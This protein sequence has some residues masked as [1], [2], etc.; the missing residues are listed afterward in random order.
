MKP[1]EN[2]LPLVSVY[3]PTKNRFTLLQK[4]V[5]SVFAQTYTNIELVICNDGSTDGT[6]KYLTNLKPAGSIKNIHILTNEESKGA[7]NARNKAIQNANG[8]FVTGL[9]DDDIFLPNRIAS[10]VEHYDPKYAFIC[11][12]MIWDYGNK[13]RT[14]DKKPGIYTLS[15]QLSYNEATTQILVERSRIL[16]LNGFD[17]SFVACQDYD[18][19]TRLIIKF[20]A[21][22]RIADVTYI[23]NDTD[24]TQRMTANPKSVKGY[25]QF[26]AKHGHLMN[27][28]NKQNQEFMKLR[29]LR[30]RYPLSNFVFHLL[31]NYR[32]AKIR[33]F[34]SSTFKKKPTN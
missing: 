7:C 1:V 31:S 12:A 28:Q 24:T 11:S 25:D 13:Q 8:Y 17:E 23:I 34:L 20:G 10:L 5:E 27:W 19:W 26:G 22:K 15:H 18:L 29:R 4:A 14:I 2:D 21:F 30:K 33:Y 9:D 32:I 3:M 6:Q 16:A